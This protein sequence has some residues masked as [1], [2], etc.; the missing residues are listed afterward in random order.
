M[1]DRSAAVL[2]A[3]GG[4]AVQERSVAGRTEPDMRE[5]GKHCSRSAGF[6][7]RRV[8]VHRSADRGAVRLRHFL[9]IPCLLW[10]SR[11]ALPLRAAF[12]FTG[13]GPDIPQSGLAAASD[14]I[15]FNF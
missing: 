9:L 5:K 1:C 4:A 13:G 10:L 2:K 11:G 12:G 15:F 7:D 14:G 8:I 3:G 6:V